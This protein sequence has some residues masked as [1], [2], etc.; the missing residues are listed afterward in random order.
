MNTSQYTSQGRN[1]VERQLG[2][3]QDSA[4]G[5]GEGIAGAREE[6][7]ARTRES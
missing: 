1:E 6:A 2:E 3:R 5:Q 4:S 7:N